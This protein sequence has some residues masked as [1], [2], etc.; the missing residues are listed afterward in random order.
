MCVLSFKKILMLTVLIILIVYFFYIWTSKFGLNLPPG[1]SQM[2]FLN[3]EG[4]MII[5]LGI[6]ATIT[7]IIALFIEIKFTSPIT[8]IGWAFYLPVLFNVLIPMFIL[9]FSVIGIFYTPWLALTD[10]DLPIINVLMNGIIVTNISSIKIIS[11]YSGYLL[12]GGGLT[13]YII[14]LYQLLLHTSKEH[15]LFKRGL[16]A[17]VRHPQYLGIVVWTLGFAVLGWRL[18]NYL[19]W[20]I[21]CY[22]YMLLLENEELDLTKLYGPEYSEYCNKVPS[23]L[24]YPISLIF[25][26]FGFRTNRK[27][28]ILFYTI[29]FILLFIMIFFISISNVVLLR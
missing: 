13:V 23:I 10:L 4:W 5:V 1:S 27:I 19:V 17:V 28:R 9:F 21:L 11:S 3:N 25:K 18:M 16:Y 22:S 20:T 7:A 14:S 26:P 12:I 24:P 6:V 15:L 29:F 2:P 8:F